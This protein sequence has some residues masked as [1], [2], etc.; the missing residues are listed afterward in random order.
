[1]PFIRPF[2][3]DLRASLAKFIPSNA[4]VPDFSTSYYTMPDTH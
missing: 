3:D 4:R 1:M 2:R